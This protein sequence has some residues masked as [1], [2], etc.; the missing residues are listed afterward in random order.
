MTK[1]I[2]IIMQTN[3]ELPVTELSVAEV[4]VTYPSALSVLTKYKIDYCCG[5]KIPFQEACEKQG[6]NTEK[7][8][9][10]IVHMRAQGNSNLR[11]TTWEPPF[12]IDYIVQ[13][14]HAYIKETVPKL[15]ELLDK[16]CDVHGEDHIELAEIR[17]DFTD[18]SQELLAHLEK[19]EKIL[20]P[21]IKS[22]FQTNSLSDLKNPIGMMEHEHQVAGDLIKSIRQLTHNYTIPRD[23][24]PTF[25]ITYKKL[26]EF[27]QDL[28]QHI[29]LENNVLFDRMKKIMN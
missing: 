19:E 3:F 21:A 5:G 15:K 2:R 23:A 13:N 22:M 16:I 6:L 17:E 4:A 24:C 18:L 26:E 7:I 14:H 27:D 25:S 20:F 12:L 9:A 10:E 1:K 11:V 29:H 28:M 8:W